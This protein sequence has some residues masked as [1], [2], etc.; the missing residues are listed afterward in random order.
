MAISLLNLKE[1]KVELVH[2]FSALSKE[3]EQSVAPSGLP[4]RSTLPRN[5]RLLGKTTFKQPSF[6]YLGRHSCTV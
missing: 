2:R 6:R 4:A 1:K 3:I 5:Q